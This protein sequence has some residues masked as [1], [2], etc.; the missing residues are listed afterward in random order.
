MSAVCLFY[1]G[2]H[3]LTCFSINEFC[4][5]FGI[6][7]FLAVIQSVIAGK[8]VTKGN[9]DKEIRHSLKTKE[10]KTDKQ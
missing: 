8:H 5:I 1:Q 6:N 10:F 7:N 2:L 9:G 3:G 4:F